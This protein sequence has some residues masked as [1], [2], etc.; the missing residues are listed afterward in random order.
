MGKGSRSLIYYLVMLLVFGKK[1]K[2]GKYR[3]LLVCQ[4][5]LLMISRKDF[6]SLKIC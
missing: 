5:R 1:V 6:L 4:M 2:L 3:K